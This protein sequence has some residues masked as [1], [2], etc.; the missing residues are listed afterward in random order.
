M[1]L[2]F[3]LLAIPAI[4]LEHY[5]AFFSDHSVTGFCQIRVLKAIIACPYTDQLGVVLANH[6]H[7]G[8]MNASLFATEGVAS[9]G[10]VL[11]PIAALACGFAIALG[12]KVST[13]LPPSFVLISAAVIPHSLLNVP[14]STTLL[15]NGLGLLMLLW[16]LTPRDYFQFEDQTIRKK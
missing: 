11:A 2:D 1:V 6:Y 9:V 15:S 14:L 3:R 7:L 12:N 13:T 16:F 4:S 8:N 5:F 10:A